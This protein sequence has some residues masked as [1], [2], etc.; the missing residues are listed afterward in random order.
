MP[1]IKKAGIEDINII[2]NI[3]MA[4]WP[5]T[6]VPIIGEAQ[7]AYMLDRFY[8]DA[9]LAAQ[10]ERGDTF[11]ICYDGERPIGFAS[12]GEVATDT[13]KLHKLYVLPETQGTG[14]GRVLLDHIQ[15]A[16]KNAGCTRLQLNVNRHN[17]G[18]K[19]FYA[20]MGFAT[21]YD[22]DIDIGNGFFMNDHV[23]ELR[24]A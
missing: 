8:S 18:A 5:G 13:Y 16:V 7:V 22:E 20:R 14:I 9:S 12:F 6:Y 24:V 23:L 21:I 19:G 15:T 3:A 2:T 4:V 10:M 1:E 17:E 11:I